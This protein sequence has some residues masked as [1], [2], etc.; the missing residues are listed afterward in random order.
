[1]RQDWGLIWKKPEQRSQ[2]HTRQFTCGIGRG[3]IG[4]QSM[5]QGASKDPNGVPNGVMDSN[6]RQT[7]CVWLNGS[8]P[9]HEL[10]APH[11]SLVLSVAQ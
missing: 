10:G 7:L 5:P 11:L 3:G 2:S 4:N 8:P 1:M 9:L 6:G